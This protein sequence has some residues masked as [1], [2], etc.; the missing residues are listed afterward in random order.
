M[1]HLPLHLFADPLVGTC[2]IRNIYNDFLDEVTKTSP[3]MVKQFIV[4]SH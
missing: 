2:A 4:E 3:N 1:A